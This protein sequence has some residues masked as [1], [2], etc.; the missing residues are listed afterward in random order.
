MAFS[1]L[2]RVNTK[3]NAVSVRAAAPR[4]VRV[5]AVKPQASK[6]VQIDLAKSASVVAVANM[7]MATP[8]FAEA[9]KIFDFNL[10]LPVMAGQFLL[11]MV[12][13]EKTWF[14]PVGKVLDERDA[15]LRSKLGSVKDNAGDVDA[16]AKEAQDILKAARQEVTA[17]INQK[18]N[19]KQDEL[20]KVYNAAKAKVNAEVEASIAAL[21]KESATVLKNLD[22][23]VEKISG[24]VLKRVLPEGVKL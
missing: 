19:A 7:I 14:T 24:E 8:A 17:M 12:F 3:A 2:A 4:S 6:D 21:E 10:T 20:D 1:T 13:L 9:G 22:D 15:L 23:Q 16:L 18:K 5:M 11:L